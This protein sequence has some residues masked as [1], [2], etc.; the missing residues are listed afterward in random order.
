M[1]LKRKVKKS[2]DTQP[3]VVYFSA[4]WCQPCVAFGPR[5]ERLTKEANVKLVKVNVDTPKKAYVDRAARVRSVPM[6][7]HVRPDGNETVLTG[8]A[9]VE[10]LQ[11]WLEA[12]K[13]GA[14]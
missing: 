6:L 13:A 10:T 4:S 3:T 2:P 14:K 1:A 7:L 5:V 12:V 11:K 8:A 9:N